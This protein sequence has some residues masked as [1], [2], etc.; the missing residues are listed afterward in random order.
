MRRHGRG[1]TA[2]ARAASSIWLRAGPVS[3]WSSPASRMPR[4]RAI[5]AAVAGWSPVIITGVIPAARHSATAAGASGRGGSIMPTTPSS[6]SPCG[7]SGGA[8]HPGACGSPGSSRRSAAARTRSPSPAR[9]SQW[10]STSPCA[11]EGRPHRATIASGAPLTRV[12]RRPPGSSCTVTI[13]LRPESKGTSSIR[14]RARRRSSGSTPRSRAASSRAISVGSPVAGASP[15]GR[16]ASL[17]STRTSIR[18]A[19]ETVSGGQHVEP[20]GTGTGAARSSGRTV[21]A[22]W[23]V[24][25]QYGSSTSTRIRFSVSVPVLSEQIQVTDPRVSTAGRR[26]TSA[27]WW[28]MRRAPRARVTATTAGRASGTAAT[29]RLIAVRNISPGS[30]PRSRPVTNT[31]AQMP[32][33]A[34]AIRPPKLDSRRCRGVR[35]TSAVVSRSAMAPSS[36]WVPVPTTTPRPRPCA[37][38]VPRKAIER[39][40]PTGACGSAT[41]S[42]RLLT[43]WDSPVRAASA[44]RKEAKEVSRRS[45]GTI[46]PSARTT[47]SPGTS[48][49]ASTCCSIPS[50]TTTAVGADM[51]RSAAIACSARRSWTTP[52]TALSS[53]MTVMTIVSAGSPT[54]PEMSAATTSSAIIGS[55]TWSRT[56]R[57]TLRP[58]STGRTLAPYAVRR[59]CASSAVRPR[60]V[61]EASA[62]TTSAA[63]RVCQRGAS[64]TPDRPSSAGGSP[65]LILRPRGG[66]A[67]LPPR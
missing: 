33:T 53:T 54:M 1:S 22:A 25:G 48:S 60:A 51:A 46:A 20:A 14:G 32:T 42:T 7:I 11:E 39:R 44:M 47:R 13:S 65:R 17:Q 31:M 28:A 59:R 6:V 2:A 16:V 37:T 64:A 9:A 45:A 36:V 63:S 3:T 15:P 8:A 57:Q 23:S 27:L 35:T 41:G 24:A 52:M 58:A 43:G 40:S 56:M 4:R 66:C 49:A 34:T 67:P 55:A 62:A 21:P 18:P 61:S 26:R 19:M 30:S 5:A 10:A 38:N 29:A 50:R 12:R